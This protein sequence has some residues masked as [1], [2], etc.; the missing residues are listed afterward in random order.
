MLLELHY[1]NIFSIFIFL[2]SLIKTDV[3]GLKDSDVPEVHNICR[4]NMSC[5]QPTSTDKS[6]SRYLFTLF[7]AAEYAP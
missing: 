5:L 4:V 2:E 1:S 3:I 6:T 7:S